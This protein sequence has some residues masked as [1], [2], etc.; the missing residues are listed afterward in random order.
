MM[1]ASSLMTGRKLLLSR[2][3]MKKGPSLWSGKTRKFDLCRLIK[4]RCL[5]LWWWARQ[6]RVKKCGLFSALL[7]GA[8]P[9]SL[10][11]WNGRGIL[12]R[13][14]ELRKQKV[15]QAMTLIRSNVITVLQEVHGSKEDF[16]HTFNKLN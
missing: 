7:K 4:T 16:E 15:R 5:H 8:K 9:L 13:K 10:C 1:K 6:R 3:Q 12:V 2:L 11:S 14:A